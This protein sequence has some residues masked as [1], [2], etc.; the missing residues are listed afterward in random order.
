MFYIG[1]D[2]SLTNTGCCVL[3]ED[4]SLYKSKTFPTKPSLDTFG[5]ETRMIHIRDGIIDFISDCFDEGCII[6]IE[7][8][9]FASRGRGVVQQA[10]IAYLIRISFF[11]KG[12]FYKIIP[13]TKVKKFATDKGNC[14]KSMMLKEVYKKW[15]VDFSCDDLADAYALS[16]LALFDE[17]TLNETV[18]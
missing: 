4:G 9:S 10:G 14:K 1:L 15:G 11:E 12:L 18:K 6:Y 7:G 13:P 3:K 5:D 8:L 17:E 2:L 16:R